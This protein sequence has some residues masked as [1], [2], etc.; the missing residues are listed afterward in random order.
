MKVEHL[1]TE[2][3]EFVLSVVDENENLNAFARKRRNQEHLFLQK[4]LTWR[5]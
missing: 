3:K 2:S 1:V 4:S 5:Q